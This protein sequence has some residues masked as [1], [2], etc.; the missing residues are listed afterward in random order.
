MVGE[1]NRLGNSLIDRTV[2]KVDA[3]NVEFQVG[4]GH[5]GMDAELCWTFL[6]ET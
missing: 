6:A 1:Q 5:H 3:A 4:A 2:T